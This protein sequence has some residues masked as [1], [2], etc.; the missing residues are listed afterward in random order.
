MTV[1][2]LGGAKLILELFTEGGLT[3]SLNDLDML[4]TKPFVLGLAYLFGWIVT[5][6]SIRV[7]GNLVLPS[8]VRIYILINLIAVCGLYIKIL[9][10]LYGQTYHLSNYITYVVIMASHC[11]AALVGM[12]FNS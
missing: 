4:L 6:I 11:L 3:I 10:K 2:L 7:F 12:H 5:I 9:L 8:I 1:T